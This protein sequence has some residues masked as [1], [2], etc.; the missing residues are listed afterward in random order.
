MAEGKTRHPCEGRGSISQ[1]TTFNG[2][3]FSERGA[4]TNLKNK[5]ADV[6]LSSCLKLKK[7]SQITVMSRLSI[8]NEV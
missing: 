1:P 5:F 2:F 7:I 6:L 4:I 8:I 3:I